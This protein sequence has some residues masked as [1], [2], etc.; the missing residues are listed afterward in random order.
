MAP[1][2]ARST[3]SV[4]KVSS[5]EI[6]LV[7]RSG[8][9][10]RSSRA[11]ARSV[12]DWACARPTTWAS[13]STENPCNSPTRWIPIRCSFSWVTGP[14][15]GMTL[16]FSPRNIS[17]SVPGSTMWQPSGLPS[18]EA[19]LARNFDD[20]IPTEEV[21]PPVTADDVRLQFGGQLPESR[22]G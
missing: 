2:S 21:I 8:S 15:P 10:A 1:S 13:S 17:T 9:T 18:S 11:Y 5:T 12:S 22:R 4:S 3:R 14:T 19:T 7:S 20:A 6:D 16:T